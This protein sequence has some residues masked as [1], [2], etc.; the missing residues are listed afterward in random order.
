MKTP[1]AQ[2]VFQ[3]LLRSK[4]RFVDTESIQ[5]KRDF[6]KGVEDGLTNR[7]GAKLEL[8][9]L[10]LTKKS[11]TETVQNKTEI[12]EIKKEEI[13]P[14]ITKAKV[15]D[16]RGTLSL[17]SQNDFKAMLAKLRSNMDAVDVETQYT[18]KSRHQ[19]YSDHHAI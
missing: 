1:E 17:Q 2:A 5:R 13:Q 6:E 4:S 8:A 15:E 7:V 16:R 19:D 12:K 14:Q 9:K 11:L 18:K 10:Q 3:E